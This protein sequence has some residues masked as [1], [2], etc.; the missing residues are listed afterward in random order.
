MN[1]SDFF[2]NVTKTLKSNSP[3]ILT[4]LGVSGVITTSYLVG[5]ASYQSAEIIRKYD[6]KS[7]KLDPK[8]KFKA[9]TKLVWKLYIPAGISGVV[10]IGCIIGS[11]KLNSKRTAAAVTAYSVAERAFSEYKEKVIEEVGKGKE[12]KIRDEL[13][14][15]RVIDKPPPSEVVVVAGGHVLCCELFTHRYFRSDM[16]ALR[17]AQNELNA[18][19][20]SQIYVSL[21]EFYDII[22]L[23]Y[24]SNSSNVGWNSDKMMELQFSTV[25]SESGEP[26]LAFDYNYI[27]PLK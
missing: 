3:E 8:Q 23:A 5:K 13:A 19:I 14:Q 7:V 9:H 12:R 26:C 11:T 2:A 24:T 22:G 17:K 18:L 1:A 10:T 20:I 25:I 6:K 16:E 4:A 21:D 27:K 15:D